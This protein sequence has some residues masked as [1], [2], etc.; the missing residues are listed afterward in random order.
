MAINKLSS[1]RKSTEAIPLSSEH[2][3]G[4]EASY[5]SSVALKPSGDPSEYSDD[6][7]KRENWGNRLEFLL[8]CVGYS[9]GLGRL[10]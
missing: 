3:A 9:V 7:V 1:N 6:S 8:A 2:L 5:E 10:S 4:G